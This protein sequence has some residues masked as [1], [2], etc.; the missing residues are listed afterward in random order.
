VWEC[1]LNVDQQFELF[2]R[3]TDGSDAAQ[4]LVPLDPGDTVNGNLEFLPGDQRVLARVSGVGGDRLVSAALDGSGAP[5]LFP[6]SY[7][8]LEWSPD[9]A[10]ITLRRSVGFG[11]YE[12]LSIPTSGGAP[13]VI[14]QVTNSAHTSGMTQSQIV[15]YDRPVANGPLL[16]FRSPLEL[17]G[18]P[19]APVQLFTTTSGPLVHLSPDGSFLTVHLGLDEEQRI[20]RIELTGTPDPVP[21]EAPLPLATIGDVTS[22]R[23]SG[24]RVFYLADQNTNGQRELYTVPFDGSAPPLRLSQDLAEG[25]SVR[26]LGLPSVAAKVAYITAPDSLLEGNLFLVPIDGSSPPQQLN[27]PLTPGTVHFGVYLSPDRTFY[28]YVTDEQSLPGFH[29]YRVPAAGGPSTP[30]VSIPDPGP[31]TPDSHGF[32]FTRDSSRFLYADTALRSIPLAGGPVQDLSGTVEA[33]ASFVVT[34]DSSR[35]VF[36]AQLTPTSSY[37]LYGNSITGSALS[38]VHLSTGLGSSVNIGSFAISDDSSRVLFLAEGQQSDHPLLYSVPVTGGTPTLLHDPAHEALSFQ[39]HG[40]HV[41]FRLEVPEPPFLL[42]E[43]IFAAGIDGSGL[44]ELFGDASSYALTPDGET[45]VAGDATGLWALAVDGSAETPLWTSSGV[46]QLS[47]ECDGS[48]VRFGN[49]LVSIRGGPVRELWDLAQPASQIEV[50][51][52]SRWA[53]IQ[54]QVDSVHEL[55]STIVQHVRPR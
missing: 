38:R 15:F 9:G 32:V 37:R 16:G 23:I 42:T 39:T 40:S 26:T 44:V 49:R 35:V 10:W 4:S 24:D 28:L 17:G 5:V 22:L 31:S 33:V 34:P 18:G 6:G 2:G 8:E 30:L 20:Y 48:Q 36:L 47:I 29:I 43:K 11:V 3:A 19:P 41:A 12:I 54:E 1:D 7:S 52:P 55:F 53:L 50:V 13:Q 45:V 25:I 27:G 14:A 21:Y 46:T 51:T